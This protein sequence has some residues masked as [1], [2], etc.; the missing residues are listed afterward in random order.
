MELEPKQ[1][2]GTA[3]FYVPQSIYASMLPS[4]ESRDLRRTLPVR[5]RG[6][7]SAVAVRARPS[8]FRKD[9]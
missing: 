7:G 6:G 5:L 4:K 9:V 2:A 8:A 3:K 1:D